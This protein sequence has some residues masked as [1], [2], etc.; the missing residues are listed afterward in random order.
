MNFDV[1][2]IGGGPGGYVAA[3]RSAQKGLKVALVEKEFLGGVCLNVGCIPSKALIHAA[4]FF[5]HI[6]KNT[7]SM[8]IKISGD[9][10]VDMEQMVSWKQSVC[11]KM[12]KGIDHLLKANGVEVFHGEAMFVLPVQVQIHLLSGGIET[13]SAQNIILAI[14]SRC[15]EIPGF[16]IDEQNILSST[17]ALSLKILPQKLTVIGGGYIG[18]E[19]GSYLAK[20]GVQ[21]SILERE[22]SLLSGLVDPECVK[23]VERKLKKQGVQIFLKT[24]VQSYEKKEGCLKIQ[25]LVE[26]VQKDFLSDQILLTVGRRPNT[27]LMNLKQLGIELD[28]LGFIK[29]NEQMRTS[30]SHIFAIGDVAGEPLLAHKASYE[31]VLVADVI[32]GIN[33]VFDA[34]VIPAVIF[35]DPEIACVG[36]TKQQ[37]HLNGYQDLKIGKFPFS[38]NGRATSLMETEGFVKIIADNKTNVVLGMH[39]CGPE[40][41]NL[42]SEG[43]LAIEMGATLEDIALSIHPHPTLGETIMECAEATLGKAIHI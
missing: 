26:G 14:G 7:S 36:W 32:S 25:A 16:S 35:T 10:E 24:T 41:S 8:G 9:V 30:V 34:K 39:I 5:H 42:I 18:L 3:I 17:G 33:R 40:A 1:L 37:C 6:Q 31:G 43:V 20:L 23:V 28:E 21:V 19:I 15:V 2:V 11:N 27:D 29:V 4:S 38:A 12:A 22:D 13:I